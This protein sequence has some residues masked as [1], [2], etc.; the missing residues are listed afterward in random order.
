MKMKSGESF[1]DRLELLRGGRSKADFCKEIG[2]SPP[3]YQKWKNGSIPGGDKL[4]L[5]SE[6]TRR[7]IKWLLTGVPITPE[8]RKELMKIT[9]RFGNTQ[10]KIPAPDDT[11]LPDASSAPSALDPSAACALCA[12]CAEKAAE[13][14][15]LREQLAKALD[16]I[17]RI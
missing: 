11:G 15:Y 7:S 6:K 9:E 1:F 8:E 13:I 3:L 16:R 12:G 17:P 10:D 2:A 4:G 5:I 14:A